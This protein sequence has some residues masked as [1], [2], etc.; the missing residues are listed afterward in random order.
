MRGI[1]R[2]L[3][4]AGSSQGAGSA[5][6]VTHASVALLGRGGRGLVIR[7]FPAAGR[8][9]VQRER[10][11]LV[12]AAV[13]RADVR[14]RREL[15]LLELVIERARILADDQVD[16]GRHVAELAA[17]R[18]DRVELVLRRPPLPAVE[19]PVQRVEV[20]A[21]LLLAGDRAALLR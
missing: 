4:P 20:L 11:E 16:R 1:L 21:D 15:V 10:A 6:G 17:Q 12:A 8:D 9:A 18:V 14:Q 19:R 7:A 5:W 3:G 2:R 13:E